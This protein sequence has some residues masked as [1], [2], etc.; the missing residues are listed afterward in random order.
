M[1]F[2]GNKNHT[3]L[4]SNIKP[5]DWMFWLFTTHLHRLRMMQGLDG[6]DGVLFARECDEGTAFALSGVVSQHRAILDRSVNLEHV[7]DVI[8]AKLL[9]EH[10]HE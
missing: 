10:A 2:E 6:R 7:S 4:E 1:K 3:I 5:W 8:F 9:R